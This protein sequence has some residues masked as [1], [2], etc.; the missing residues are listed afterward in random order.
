MLKYVSTQ[1]TCVFMERHYARPMRSGSEIRD[2]SRSRLYR[3]RIDPD[4]QNETNRRCLR[5]G[6]YANSCQQIHQ[7]RTRTSHKNRSDSRNQEHGEKNRLNDSER[8]NLWSTADHGVL[9]SLQNCATKRAYVPPVR[10]LRSD[11]QEHLM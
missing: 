6:H 5:L 10:T 2:T 7:Q 9:P 8:E 3:Q 4:L 1:Y 11:P